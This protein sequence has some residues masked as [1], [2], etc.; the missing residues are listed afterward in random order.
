MTQIALVI[1]RRPGSRYQGALLALDL[2]WAALAMTAAWSLLPE[3]TP[4]PQ[5]VGGLITLPLLALMWCLSVYLLGQY[6]LRPWRAS[7]LI[8]LEMFEAI[9]LGTAL[10]LG[11]SYLLM[12]GEMAGRAFYLLAAT[13]AWTLGAI[14][15]L[16]FVE[17]L[18][19]RDFMHRY[20]LIGGGARAEAMA[21]ALRGPHTQGVE[22]VGGIAL[23]DGDEQDASF[24]MLGSVADLP[25]LIGERELT[26]AVLCADGEAV[27]RAVAECEMRGLRVEN[28]PNAFERVTQRAPIFAGGSEWVAGI[29]SRRKT[30]YATRFKRVL[31]IAVAL[32]LLPAAGVI[33]AVAAA[34]IKL[35][36]RGPVFYTQTRVGRGGREFRF[37]KLRTMV[38]E[39]EH[40]TGPV[41]ATHNDPRVTGVG[42]FLRRYRLD[43][44]PQLWSVL[45]GEMS[46][47]GPRPERPHFVEQFI[48]RIPYYRLRLLAPPGISGWAQIHRGPDQTEEDVYEK[49]RRDLYYVRHL[50]F[51]LDLQVLARTAG[52]VLT[53]GPRHGS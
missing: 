39:A 50:S 3:D 24:A 52:V 22:L 30:R 37:V 9:G 47:V 28:I 46:L 49:L 15:R 5:R 2:L 32:A 34:G 12:P 31:D 33:L 14:T 40:D 4:D 29:E 51:A 11:L 13:G 19:R 20:V 53:N 1:P 35:T 48:E 41:W 43:E 44:L 16:A 27:A 6:F 38:D 7:Y 10:T 42:R 21:N 25:R 17:L 45:T 18:P 36:S 23:D 26:H 8:V